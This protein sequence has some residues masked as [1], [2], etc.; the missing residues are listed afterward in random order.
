MFGKIPQCVERGGIFSPDNPHDKKGLQEYPCASWLLH[1]FP[2]PPPRVY[3]L[4]CML[5]TRSWDT[6][7]VLMGVLGDSYP[8]VSVSKGGGSRLPLPFLFP[9]ILPAPS[10]FVN[11]PCKCS[12]CSILIF[13][14]SLGSLITPWEAL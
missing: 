7:S 3:Y 13:S 6:H 14:H 10:S 11:F 12:H 1:F 4:Y 8:V 2:E 5:G 9:I